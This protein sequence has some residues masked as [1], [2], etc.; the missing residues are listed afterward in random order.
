MDSAVLKQRVRDAVFEK[1]EGRVAFTNVDISHPIISDDSSVRHREVRAEIDA[2]WDAGEIQN[3]EYTA[4]TITVYPKPSKPVGARLFHPDEP[5]YDPDE[6][7]ATNQ[8][9]HRSG[10]GTSP[11]LSAPVTTGFQMTDDDGDDGSQD[12]PVAIT[13]TVG[14]QQVT[15]QCQVMPKEGS[16]NIPRHLIKQAGFN[17]GDQIGIALGNSILTI[18]KGGNDQKVDSEGRIRIH[19]PNASNLGQLGQSVTALLVTPTG[20]DA[21]IQVQ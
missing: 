4:S 17:A 9:L 7:T 1:I 10:S 14:G 18:K 8:E 6:Y 19:G 20:E 12:A 5:D 2:L 21:F 3:E 16:I 11:T 15:R 13:S